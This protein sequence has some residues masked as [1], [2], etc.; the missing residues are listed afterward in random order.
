MKFLFIITFC[1]LSSCS[2]L[3]RTIVYSSLSGGMAGSLAG[4]VLSPTKKD[5][6]AN[7]LVFGAI[8]A[9][10]AALSGYALYKDDPRNY[11]L[12]QMLTPEK[13]NPN[14]ISLGL[15]PLKLNA[16]LNKKEMYRV[17]VR[18]LP[19]KLKGKVGKQYLIKYHAKERYIKLGAK[20]Y[21]IPAFEIFEY[22]YGEVPGQA[23]GKQ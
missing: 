2:S 21:Y 11:K 15:G 23:G 14:S 7:A 5:R 6:G 3:K 19:D 22:T 17:P 20:T 1:L 10:L 18:E 13:K 16:Q 4:A 12:K 8:G 9:G